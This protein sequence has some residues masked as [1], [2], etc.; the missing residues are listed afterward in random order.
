[1][2][3]FSLLSMLSTAALAFTL[4]SQ[5]MAVVPQH[6]NSPTAQA[7]GRVKF[8]AGD[9]HRL[10]PGLADKFGGEYITN[11][12]ADTA[13]FDVLVV[14]RDGMMEMVND[15]GKRNKLKRMLKRSKSLMTI[16][17]APQ[18]IAQ[19]LDVEVLEMHPKTERYVAGSVTLIGLEGS[20]SG[21]VLV[22]SEASA[23]LSIDDLAA[24]IYDHLASVYNLAAAHRKR[25]PGLQAYYLAP[26]IASNVLDLCPSYL[27]GYGKYNEIATVNRV[28][29]DGDW[30]YDYWSADIQQQ[31]LG[32]FG[33]C[34]TNYRT[35][36]LATMVDMKRMDSTERLYRYGP[37]TT[38]RDSTAAVNIGFST[39]YAPA[40]REF[41]V[42]FSVS[43]EWS[44]TTPAVSVVDRSDFST[45]IAAWTF[46]YD[47]SADAAKYTY[48]SE[49]GFSLRTLQTHGMGF[50]K[51]ST[52]TWYHSIYTDPSRTV[53]WGYTFAR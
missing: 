18:Q 35:Y 9:I 21:G 20:I 5:A 41:S 38:N 2:S 48:T 42:A 3:R 28:E 46:N 11:D 23:T 47:P 33:H 51:K 32:G 36:G 15:Q 49:P 43:K 34:G 27:G 30:T 22:P 50:Y 6:A 52:I 10:P 16:G 1:M 40:D 8:L 53:D 31:T 45:D 14:S 26:K 12:Q 17:A 44:F 4:G 25:A 37:T 19:E 39:G 24:D 7:V 29:D 13:S